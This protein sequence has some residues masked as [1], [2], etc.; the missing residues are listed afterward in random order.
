MR[1]HIA[2]F[3]TVGHVPVESFRRVLAVLE[4]AYDGLAALDAVLAAPTPAERASRTGS[5][6]QRRRQEASDARDRIDL[7]HRYLEWPSALR[8][9]EDSLFLQSCE[10]GSPG[11]FE[12]LGALNPL[13]VLRR[14]LNDRHERQKDRQYRNKLEAER[15]DLENMLL[16][17]EVFGERLRLIKEHVGDVEVAPVLNAWVVRPLE[18]VGRESDAGLLLPAGTLTHPDWRSSSGAP[19]TSSSTRP[20]PR[21]RK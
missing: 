11:F 10:V 19:T 3:D 17:N 9:A 6:V 2:R 16:Q 14:Y 18:A 8:G 7:A 4:E 15:L 13:E 1:S 21:R 12:F 20:A 5:A